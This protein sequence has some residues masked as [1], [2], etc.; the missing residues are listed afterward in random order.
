MVELMA[1]LRASGYVDPGWEHGVAQDERKKKVKCNYCGKIV[2]GGVYRLKQHLARVSGEVTYC[3]KAPEEVYL[4]M[5]ENLEGTRSHKKRK[6]IE[7][8]GHAYLNFHSSN[9]EEEEEFVAYRSKGKQLMG[10][11]NFVV[12]LT[13]LRSLGY[14]DPGWEHGVAQDEKKKKVKC[15]YCEKIVS[16]GINRFK[17]H[18]ARIPGEVAPCRD[19]PDDV[20]IKIKDNMKW[21]RTG[22][23]LK[24]HVGNEITPSNMQLDDDEE[25]E[26]EQDIL[27]SMSR[28]RMRMS[29]KRLEKDLRK[30]FHG[31]PPGIGSD[32]FL[33]KS[34]LDSVFLRMP[35]SP[36]PPSCKQM[37]IRAGSSKKSRKEVV[38]AICKF[39]YHAG[40]PI[41]A[42]NSLYF[43]KMLEMVSQ[44]G[45]GLGGPSSQLLSGRLL[46]EEIATIKS[47]VVEC[48]ASWSITGCSIKADSW[49]DIEGKTLINFLASCPHGI[50]FV[51]SVDATDIVEDASTLF[52][53]LDK[54]VEE[55]GEENVVQVITK[56]TPV[57]KAAGK[58]LEEKRRNLFWT[59]CAIYCIDQVLENF[60]KI[61]HIGE[62]ME[63]GQKITKLIYNQI[64]LLNLM[65]KEITKGQELLRPTVTRY[66]SSFATLQ[67]LLDHRTGLRRM[68]QCSKWISSPLS[69]SNEG[70]EVERIVLNATF[71]K[72]VQYIRKLV[73]PI[74]DVLLKV[75]NSENLS[76]PYLYSDLFRVKLSIKSIHGDDASKYGPFWSVIDDHWNSLFHH[77]LYRAAYYLNPSYRY[78]PDF[79]VHSEVVRGLNECIVRLEPDKVRR[80]SASVQISD[81]SSA[82]ADFGMELAITTRTEL[83][84]AAW[85]QQHGISCLELQRIAVHILS[86][87]CSSIGC[88]HYWSIYDQIHS[89]RYSPLSQERVN[90]LMYVH[91]N[92]RLRESQIRR[93]NNST[94]L[95]S[96]TPEILLDEWIVEAERDAA[97]DKGIL[98]NENRATHEDGYEN[99]MIDYE[100]EIE[101]A[102]KGSL[103]L[104]TASDVDADGDEDAD[105]NFC[106]DDSSD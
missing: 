28:E 75:D 52:K 84:P 32:P 5:K 74:I 100:D 58:M 101:E 29:D 62:C 24:Q 93:S 88:E 77:P 94:P 40:V 38:S 65:K 55:I 50:Y 1:P 33:R 7:N 76:M 104:A 59:P 78:R 9:G 86:Q 44:Y 71:W 47:Y 98:D 81:Y 54:V 69:K 15:N 13:P 80:S 79:V 20:Y 73:N 91:Y 4:R 2:S 61:K 95:E 3:D 31:M 30:T 10:D 83:D 11:R 37:K 19:A 8:D 45:E 89:Q 64:W 63:K 34:R 66:A 46:Q 12:S 70:K 72:K 96:V 16:G 42:A 23:R 106:D 90:D 36:T 22:R 17:Q 41:Q 102:R 87:T 82:K 48:K 67:S 97:Q 53:L 35:R 6:H 56:N 14:V 25:D 105:L 68:F 27:H 92:L 99:V 18:L 85:W 57:Y 39:F 26:P 103:E 49:T 51:S 21:H 60:L 43:Q